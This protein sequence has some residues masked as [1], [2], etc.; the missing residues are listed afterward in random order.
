MSGEW[1][2]GNNGQEQGL[3]TPSSSLSTDAFH[4]DS[5]FRCGGIFQIFKIMEL[6]DLPGGFY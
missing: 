5:R 3:Q 4:A 1:V 2:N 6:L